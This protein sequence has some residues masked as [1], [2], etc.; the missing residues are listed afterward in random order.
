MSEIWGAVVAGVAVAGIS[1]AMSGGAG[2]TGVTT[3]APNPSQTAGDVFGAEQQYAA[4]VYGLTQQYAPQYSA[5]QSSLLNQTGGNLLNT[6]GSAGSGLTDLT[7]T[8]GGTAA[9]D[10]TNLLNYMAPGFMQAYQNAD[11]Q[12]AALQQQFTNMAMTQ[13]NP[14]SQIQGAG[15]W[16]QQFA[17]SSTN[18]INGSMVNAPMS[19]TT[20]GAL[21]GFQPGVSTVNPQMQVRTPQ[22][23]TLNQLNSTAQQQLALGTSISPQEQATVANQVLSNYNTMGRAEDPTAI[24]G[25]ATGLDTY[26]QQLLQQRESAAS[27]A[28]GLTT[29]QGGLN[30]SA[31]QS[32]LNASQQSQLAN[33]QAYLTGSGQGLSALQTQASLGQQTN[34]ANQASSLSSQQANLQSQVASQGLNLNALYGSSQQQL[35]SQFANQQAQLS[36]ANYQAQLLG[37]ASNLAYTTAQ[38][39]YNILLNGGQNALNNTTGLINQAGNTVTAGNQL[40]GLYNPFNSTF[41]SVYGA[42]ANANAANAATNA[43]FLSG[44]LSLLGSSGVQQGISNGLNSWFGGGT[45][46]GIGSGGADFGGD[47]T[48]VSEIG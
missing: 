5:L 1:S 9:N 17:Q 38:N 39:P 40:S 25:L 8:L 18:A 27:N 45:S 3:Q 37:S 21:N 42:Q 29:T 11:P 15:Q 41:N 46:S 43:G 4:P 47:S 19:Q 20:A 28:A 36:N 32:N 48:E 23:N 24:A 26:G 6:Y 7:S 10:N 34:L 44:G 30:L 2:G 16:G 13:Q 33:Q 31:Q 35:Q 12:L 14:V 22:N